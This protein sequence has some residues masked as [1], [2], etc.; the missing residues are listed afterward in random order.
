MLIP[1][2][3]HPGR[4]LGGG[5][6]RGREVATAQSDGQSSGTL[7]HL[8]D[9]SVVGYTYDLYCCNTLHSIYIIL[10]T[11]ISDGAIR[12]EKLKPR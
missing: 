10:A 3:E 12:N 7:A 5:A 11:I 4:P 8:P 1:T 6:R 9:G 2:P